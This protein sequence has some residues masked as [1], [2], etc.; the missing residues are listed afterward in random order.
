MMRRAAAGLVVIAMLLAGATP[1]TG[2]QASAEARH[3]CCV[4]GTCPDSLG[5]TGGQTDISQEAAD[6]CCASSE[7]KDQRDGSQS[8]AAFF[9]VPPPGT[10]GD[11]AHTASVSL[12]PSLPRHLPLAQPAAPLYVLYSVFLV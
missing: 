1:C 11:V 10:L 4:N 3:D 8:A 2:W 12:R 6:Q 5:E 7:G 9:A